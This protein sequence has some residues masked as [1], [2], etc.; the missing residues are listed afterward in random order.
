MTTRADA[1]PWGRYFGPMASGEDKEGRTV[2]FSDIAGAD[3]RVV[4]I[5]WRVPAA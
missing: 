4:H 2:Y 5:G 3:A 1:S